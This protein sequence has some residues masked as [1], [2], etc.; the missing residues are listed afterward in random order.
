MND[1]KKTFLIELKNVDKFFKYGKKRFYALKNINLSIEKGE[2]IVVFGPSG[3]GKTTLLYILSLID[4]PQSGEIFYKGINLSNYSEDDLA[5]FRGEHFGFIFQDY[6]LLP[7]YNVLYNVSLPLIYSKKFST[8]EKLII[9]KESLNK[10]DLSDK[11]Y[12]YPLELSGGEAQRVAIARALV[13]NPD[14]IFADEPTGNLDSTTGDR[15]IEY[16]IRLNNELGVTIIL[17]THNEK[18]VSLG[19][20][21]IKIIDGILEC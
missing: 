17:S 21:I 5:R 13:N 18:Y 20:R 14:I 1:E 9:A 3:A 16:F 2:F 8:K 12:N 7:Q 15:I 19:K 4:K 6:K 11:L 10:V